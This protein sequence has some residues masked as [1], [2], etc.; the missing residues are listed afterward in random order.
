MHA[1]QQLSL[2]QA[3]PKRVTVSVVGC[4]IWLSPRLIMVLHFVFKNPCNFSSN[5]NGFLSTLY[6]YLIVFCLEIR[7]LLL[8]CSG[9]IIWGRLTRF[10]TFE[11]NPW[12]VHG[13]PGVSVCFLFIYR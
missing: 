5:L 8:I 11:K 12:A 6:G 13:V 9:G 1:M 7:K 2:E 10:A 3:V 4:P